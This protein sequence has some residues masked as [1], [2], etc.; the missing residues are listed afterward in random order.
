MLSE[1]EIKSLISKLK[2]YQ[3]D[4]APMLYHRKYIQHIIDVLEYII[5]P[6]IIK[7]GINLKDITPI[8]IIKEVYKMVKDE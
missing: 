1:K 4:K 2:V 3:K 5:N 6:A 8:D 7:K